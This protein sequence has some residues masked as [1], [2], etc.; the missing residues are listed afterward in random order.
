MPKMNGL[1]AARLIKEISPDMKIIAQTAY[2]T[3]DDRQKAKLAGCIG[4]IEKPIDV[5]KFNSMINSTLYPEAAE[6]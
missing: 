6:N 4:F 5:D 3:F 2:S 1:E